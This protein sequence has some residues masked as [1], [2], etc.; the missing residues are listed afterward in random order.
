[1]FAF[2]YWALSSPQIFDNNPPEFIFLNRAADPDHPY[3]GFS[4][5]IHQAHLALG[6]FFFWF[7]RITYEVLFAKVLGLCNVNEESDEVKINEDV[8]K[9][10]T[11][12]MALPHV[13]TLHTNYVLTLCYRYLQHNYNG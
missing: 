3:I 5:G 6:I 4:G 10:P 2:G 9:L 1:M 11:Y 8:E 12:W 7:G 13:W